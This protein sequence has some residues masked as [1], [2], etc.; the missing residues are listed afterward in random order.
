MAEMDE[1]DPR[2]SNDPADPHAD[3]LARYGAPVP[4]PAF[5]LPPTPPAFQQPPHRKRHGRRLL[6]AGAALAVVG[7][8]T[9]AGFLLG[10]ADQQGQQDAGEA[11]SRWWSLSGP[12]S[13]ALSV[14][15]DA[16]AG[17]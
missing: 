2:P 6:A 15:R 12:Q 13:P 16:D 17:A 4:P 7:A 11:F 9:G 5:P 3:Y 1:H 10:R 8:A 14:V